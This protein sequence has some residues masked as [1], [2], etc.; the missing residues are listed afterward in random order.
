MFG[1]ALVKASMATSWNAF[2]KVA[3][4]PLRVTSPPGSSDFF[5]GFSPVPSVV[6][7]SPSGALSLLLQATGRS[8]SARAPATPTIFVVE[9]MEVKVRRLRDGGANRV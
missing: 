2:W 7:A 4:L 1:L 5:S 6:L 3:P 8:V 9:I